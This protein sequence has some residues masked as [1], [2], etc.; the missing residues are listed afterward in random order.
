MSNE[1]D[2]LEQF[3]SLNFDR[4]RI[5]RNDP[6]QDVLAPKEHQAFA[7][8]VVADNPM[9]AIPMAAAIPAYTA[10]KALNRVPEVVGSM[11]PMLQPA[12]RYMQ[13]QT[14]QAR[15][16]PSIQEMADAYTGVL[17]GLIDNQMKAARE[18]P[19]FDPDKPHGMGY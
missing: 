8:G 3:A 13:N 12:M 10:G 7:R 5:G 15:S 6:R 11:P 4:N 2:S 16:K 9:L 18:L 17:Q 19:P 14:K 1:N